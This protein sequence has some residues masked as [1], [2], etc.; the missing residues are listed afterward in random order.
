MVWGHP[1]ATRDVRINREKGFIPT[2][3]SYTIPLA[4]CTGTDTSSLSQPV[5]EGNNNPGKYDV[6]G[7]RNSVFHTCF[8]PNMLHETRDTSS[9]SK[10]HI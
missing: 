7:V 6:N 1:D 3:G 9:F 2:T 8:K 5:P 4:S 10:Y